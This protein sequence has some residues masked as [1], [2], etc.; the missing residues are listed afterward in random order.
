M[1]AS[2]VRRL[3]LLYRYRRWAPVNPP[4]GRRIHGEGTPEVEAK[5]L[6]LERRFGQMSA[7]GIARFLNTSSLPLIASARELGRP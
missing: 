7:A 4:Y 5:I 3:R 6:D 2:T 1:I